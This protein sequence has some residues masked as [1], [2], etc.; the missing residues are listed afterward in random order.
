MGGLGFCFTTNTHLRDKLFVMEVVAKSNLSGDLI[1]TS[2][3]GRQFLE[4][5]HFQNFQL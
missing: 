2:G 5:G 1:S 4:P 3:N